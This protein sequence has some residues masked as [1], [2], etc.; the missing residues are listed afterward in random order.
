MTAGS[1]VTTS[2]A[3]T[4]EIDLGRLAALVLPTHLS[5]T[6]D[7]VGHIIHFSL[8]GV[9]NDDHLKSLET[10][11]GDCGELLRILKNLAADSLSARTSIAYRLCRTLTAEKQAELLDRFDALIVMPEAGMAA[12]DVQLLTEKFVDER[13][14]AFATLAAPALHEQC[15]QEVLAKVVAP[16]AT[17]LEP[18]LMPHLLSVPL[19]KSPT[20]NASA[21]KSSAKAISGIDLLGRIKVTRRTQAYFC[22]KA[23]NS[24]QFIFGMEK[25]PSFSV[26]GVALS[27]QQTSLGWQSAAISMT[28]GETYLLAASS[29]LFE[30]SWTTAQQPR[31][32][33]LVFG[34]MFPVQTI[35]TVASILEAAKSLMRLVTRLDLGLEDFKYLTSAGSSVPLSLPNVQLKDLQM[36]DS[37]RAMRDTVT[38]ETGSLA[39]TLRW[40]R[41]PSSSDNVAKLCT[42]LAKGFVWSKEQIA[43]VIDAKYPDLPPSE[44]Y[45]K[46]QD[47]R[48][49]L[50][51][52]DILGI[53]QRLDGSTDR[54]LTQPVLMLFD[55]AVPRPPHLHEAEAAAASALQLCLTPTQ[56]KEINKSIAER[57]RTVLV[58]LLL[59]QEY[60]KNL[61][62]ESED[63]LF[64]YF[65]IDVQMGVQLETTRM[66]QAISTVQI[67]VQRCLLGLEAESGIPS[68]IISQSKWAWMQRHNT[69]Q[70]TR[71]AFLY[72]ENW[73]EPSLRDD[74]TPLFDEFE[75]A[76]MHKDLSWNSFVDAI[77]SYAQGLGAIADLRVD[78]Y[79]REHRPGSAEIYHFFGR[80]RHA[81]FEFFYRSMSITRPESFVSWTPWRKI[82]VDI[83][84]HDADWDG[85]SIPEGGSY[86]IPVHRNGRLFLFL[87]QIFV[88]TETP[89]NQ[90][91]QKVNPSTKEKETV[92]ASLYEMAQSPPPM[93]QGPS[94][95]EIRMGWTELANGSWTPKRLSD[96]FLSVPWNPQ[97]PEHGLPPLAQFVF[98]SKVNE[99][100]VVINVGYWASE[101]SFCELG[102]FDINNNRIACLAYPGRSPVTLQAKGLVTAFHKYSWSAAK[103]PDSKVL[104]PPAKGYRDGNSDAPLLAIQHRDYAMDLSWTLSFSDDA[105]A[106]SS[107]LVVDEKKSSSDGTSVFMYPRQEY[108]ASQPDALK[109]QRPLTSADFHNSA[110]TEV[111]EHEQ[112]QGLVEAALRPDDAGLQGLLSSMDTIP[113]RDYGK[114]VIQEGMSKYHELATSYAVYN[115]ELGLHAMLMAVD[116]FHTTQQFELALKAAR[117]VFDPTASSASTEPDVARAA[118]WKFKPFRDLAADR[119]SIIDKAT[120]WPEDNKVD[121]AVTERKAHP[122]ITHASA[123]GRPQAYMKWVIMKYIQ[124]LCD[125]GDAYF[126]QGS[127]E[128]LPLAIQRYMEADHVLGPAPPKVPKLGKP[129]IR[130]WKTLT[131]EVNLELSFPFLCDITKRGSDNVADTA[132]DQSSILGYLR[133]NYFC[134]PANPQYEALRTLVQDRLWKARNNLDIN[135]RPIVYSM[136]EPYI[137]PGQMARALQSGAAGAVSSLI[138]DRDSPMPYQ[139]FSYLVG[140]ALE[141]CNELRAMGDQFLQAKE[142]Q[143]SEALS[144]LKA[145]QDTVRQKM[146]M[147]LK[148]LQRDEITKTIESLQLTRSSTVS[149]LQYYLSLIGEPHSRVPRADDEWE[150]LTQTIL[151][152]ITDSLRMS[153][154]EMAEMTYSAAATGMNVVAGSMEAIIGM[155]RAIP[156]VT[157]NMQP[158]GCG[159]SVKADAGNVAEGSQGVVMA[160][161]LAAMVSSELGSQAARAGNLTKQLQERR[162]Q[163]NIR[164]REIKNIDKQIEIQLKRLDMNQTEQKVQSEEID[165]A[166]ETE[167]WYRSK[168]TNENLYMW[169]EKSLRSIH[170][171]LYN[172]TAD[173]CRQAERAARFEKGP[174]LLPST[175][176]TGGHWDSSRDGL[177]AAQ[178]MQLNLRR[179]E[180]AY[181]LKPAYDFELTKNVS[182]RQLDP[183]ALI[184]LR[185]TA[186]ATFSLPETL[187]DLDFPGHYMRRLRS[188]SV[189]IPCIVGPYTTVAATLT[190]TEHRYRVSAAASSA[191]TYAAGN[192][193][194]GSFRNDSIPISQVAI[195]SGM[196]DSGTFELNFRQDSA[197]FQPFEGAGAVSSWRL[198]LPAKSIRQ[199]NY[200]T[201]SDV[202][203][204][205]RYTA[206]SG[207][208]ILKRA[209]F[210]ALAAAQTKA[211]QLMAS[212][213]LWGYL[214]VKNDLANQ[215]HSFRS[216]LR[217][218][219]R[220]RR[221]EVD[222]QDIMVSRLPL[223]C[224]GKSVLIESMWIVIG[225]DVTKD[226][227]FSRGISVPAL[228]KRALG[229]KDIG[230]KKMLSREGANIA[231]GDEGWKLVVE[232]AKGEVC[233][234]EDIYIFFRYVLEGS[235]A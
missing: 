152:P 40:L 71:R 54:P 22:P 142:K 190:L 206:V 19:I 85:T 135:G 15:V 128:T 65:M 49:L 112:A 114:A 106:T 138:S 42:E 100:G 136:M 155:L 10:Q 125:A 84:T 163:A 81:P 201:I 13:R 51:M 223:W 119:T 8:Y 21:L 174:A 122:S 105:L 108:P 213:G 221:A 55:L 130:S 140:K 170:F 225:G 31:P 168:Y 47:F 20:G 153:P 73:L 60:V 50:S 26:N 145:R 133:T 44:I 144:C 209:A 123:R 43:M 194:D 95:Y 191:E 6:E 202:V 58:Q 104:V 74:K 192:I 195:S 217:A 141:L 186:T 179:L 171:D 131:E 229:Q 199:F 32:T 68:K 177:L 115:W 83:T 132:T 102:R 33:K 45:K 14:M 161:K 28:T 59:Q 46:F 198:E 39:R 118:C 219:D 91:V 234:I 156:N 90:T 17:K 220:E 62:I 189:S 151:E 23:T 167:L 224:Q 129:V 235:P 117:L 208:P 164:G 34:N 154:F 1:Q 96:T 99:A 187:F 188:V 159:V 211:Q 5:I 175:S 218:S 176:Q 52:Q 137:D 181:L 182:L 67:F 64:S 147:E 57:K 12:E 139:R 173:L 80:S 76:I 63:G 143:D 66:K 69:W 157:T 2:I 124:I 25:S 116:R 212:E 87:P 215:W 86:L 134:L 165:N 53:A 233:G 184:S 197:Q 37:Y 38:K 180:S 160:L 196:Q 72:P 210:E 126:R 78:A 205:L 178:E 7:P 35:N 207:G 4:S 200:D 41:D 226:K 172:L 36:L 103:P 127:F 231:L 75:T 120:A 109:V 166:V 3:K 193:A 24:Y 148:A 77:R 222:L 98:E 110:V 150:D 216:A 214:E 56:L 107:G 158:M 79:L 48:E 29:D 11:A 227:L 93:Q 169:F 27:M 16:F 88:K 111:I 113:E 82:E 230:S 97:E 9:L 121:A 228:G 232:R 203:L 149:Q 61:G 70:A 94:R 185:E 204:H 101:K 18:S 89:G 162:L 146:Q 30:A 183:L 92:K